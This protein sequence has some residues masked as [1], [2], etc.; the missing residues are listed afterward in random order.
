VAVAGLTVSL[1]LPPGIAVLCVGS[2]GH[3][4]LESASPAIATT[5]GDD[6]RHAV[7]SDVDSCRCGD[8]CGPCTDTP[9]GAGAVLLRL[10]RGPHVL[11]PP[12]AAMTTSDLPAV[13]GPPTIAAASAARPGATGAIPFGA[14][15]RSVVLLI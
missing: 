13:A 14:R 12:G 9:I 10:P 3:V 7:V 2:G 4:A 15:L 11:T 8:D 6:D 5:A 1:S